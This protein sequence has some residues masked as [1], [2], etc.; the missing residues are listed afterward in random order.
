MYMYVRATV[1]VG[2]KKKFRD[3]ARWTKVDRIT[4]TCCEGRGGRVVSGPWLTGKRRFRRR[5]NI[6]LTGCIR[7][8]LA[9]P[10]ALLFTAGAL[11]GTKPLARDYDNLE[12]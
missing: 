6:K 5:D 7:A 2:W 9:S 1:S 10:A 8:F 3:V 12:P 11:S 4:G